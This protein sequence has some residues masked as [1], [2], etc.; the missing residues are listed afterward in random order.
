MVVTQPLSTR[1]IKPNF[2]FHLP[3]RR[4]TTVSLETRKPSTTVIA[5]TTELTIQDVEITI[6]KV[7]LTIQKVF[8]M[9]TSIDANWLSGRVH[10]DFRAVSVSKVSFYWVYSIHTESLNVFHAANLFTNSC[11]NT[12][13]NGK[14]P[15]HSHHDKPTTPYS[16]SIRSDEEL[17]LKTSAF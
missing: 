9:K 6:Q 1:L 17:K 3:H 8:L 10:F 11:H 7:E 5:A 16:S 12:S 13:T 14:A 15:P 4:S 2:C